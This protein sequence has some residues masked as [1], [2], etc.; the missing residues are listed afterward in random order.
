MECKELEAGWQAG[1]HNTRNGEDGNRYLRE[2]AKIS[3]NSIPDFL[4]EGDHTV[5]GIFEATLIQD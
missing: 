5:H 2:E 3:G 4:N 1:K